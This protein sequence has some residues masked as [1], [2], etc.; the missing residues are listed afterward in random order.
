MKRRK[1]SEKTETENYKKIL[2]FKKHTTWQ[3]FYNSGLWVV[4]SSA[5]KLNTIHP[6]NCNFLDCIAI[7]SVDNISNI[8]SFDL[9]KKLFATFANLEIFDDS[10]H[11][12]LFAKSIKSAHQLGKREVKLLFFSSA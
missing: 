2:F 10:A 12:G 7:P 8:K 4:V 11:T 1:D 3:E 6:T 9:S 5:E